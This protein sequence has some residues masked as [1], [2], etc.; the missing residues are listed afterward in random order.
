MIHIHPQPYDLHI[1]D[2]HFTQRFK[3]P[4]AQ[5]SSNPGG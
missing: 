2:P 4:I 5:M 1:S 3:Q